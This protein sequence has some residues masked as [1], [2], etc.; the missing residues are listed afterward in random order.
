[1]VDD[2]VI[3]GYQLHSGEYLTA[4]EAT[5]LTQSTPTAVVVV[6]GSARSGKTSLVAGVY[7]LLQKGPLGKL[8][9]AGSQSLT[10]FE[11]RCHL[12]TIGSGLIGPDMERTS[13]DEEYRFLHLRVRNHASG[14]VVNVLFSDISGETFDDAANTADDCKRLEILHRA[15]SVAVLLDG[16]K[17]CDNKLRQQA[18]AVVD[19]LL[20]Q[21]VDCNMLSA[22]SAVQ[23]IVSKWDLVQRASE[24]Q[25]E[26][27]E[28]KL[29]YLQSQYEPKVGELTTY[30]I[31]L[32]HWSEGAIGTSDDLER[33]VNTW[34]RMQPIP[35]T[36]N[37]KT[38]RLVHTEFDRFAR[39]DSTSRA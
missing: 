24:R 4:A 15:D 22:R 9:F 2:D 17:A 36:P 30:R 1:M 10:G 33:L 19:S 13:V 14:D 20:G 35:R 26:F 38:E 39:V 3:T 31:A 8:Y 32:R 27:I 28:Q 23:L 16:R 7:A 12:A 25:R 29:T 6:G 21:C 18:F 5:A 34:L 11:Q 37:I